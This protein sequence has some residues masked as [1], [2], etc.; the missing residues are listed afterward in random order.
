MKAVVYHKYGSPDVLELEE[1]EKSTL[2]DDEMLVKVHEASVISWDWDLLRGTPFLA[3]LMAGGLLKPRHK[4]LGTDIAGRDEEV[5]K[6]V[7]QL[8][9]RDVVFGELSWRCLSL[10]WGGFAE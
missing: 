6:N 7:K 1:I 10:G 4:I 9:Q 8:Q 5:G 2:R 3:R